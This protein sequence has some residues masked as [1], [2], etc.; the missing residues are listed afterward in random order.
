MAVRDQNLDAVAP[1]L[2]TFT[3]KQTTGVDDL[4]DANIGEPVVLTASGEVG[5]IGDGDQ[6]LGRLISLTLSD[7]DDGDRLATVQVGGICRLAITTTYPTVGNRV[8]GGASGTV[9][10]APTVA[11]DPAGGNVARGTVLDVNGTTDCVILL[12]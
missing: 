10:Q 9:K 4:K 8:V 3:I 6:L 12:N 5:P 7:N 1:V 11:S 2:A